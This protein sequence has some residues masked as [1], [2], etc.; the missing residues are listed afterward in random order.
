[1]RKIIALVV[2]ASVLGCGSLGLAC[3]SAGTSSG[4]S[5]PG[6][7]SGA[8]GTSGTSGTS[9]ASGGEGGAA[10]AIP[11]GTFLYVSRVTDKQHVLMAYDSTNGETRVVTDLRG[12]GSEGWTIDGF[13][14]SPDRT[15]I[16]MASLYGPTKADVDT[17]LSSQR[18][19]S[20]AADGSDYRRLTPVWQNSGGGRTGWNVQVRNPMFTLSGT[21]VIYGYGEYWYEGTTLKGGSDLWVVSSAGGGVPSYPQSPVTC[22]RVAP[23]VDPKTGKVAVLHSVCAGSQAGIYLYAPDGSGTPEPLVVDSN[24]LSTSLEA[25][26]WVGDGS[27][28]VFIGVTPVTVNGSTRN[29]Q[30]L[31][32]FDM[33]SR[34]PSAVVVPEEPDT[35][36]VDAT[37][38]PDGRALVYCLRKGDAQ[39]LHLI[40]LTKTPATDTAITKD[41]KS[42]HAVW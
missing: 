16:V 20:F 40:D 32:A 30:G 21:D 9:G 24:A 3:S 2:L 10:G 18:L 19:W 38:A 1:M 28:F 36:V 8:S 14:I 5:P 29:G 27:V 33:A 7:S 22:S 15:R 23:S 12:D 31:F 42:C 4:G 26:R 25:P 39:D 34:T 35:S 6:A 17:G 37:I 13:S 41:G 11:T